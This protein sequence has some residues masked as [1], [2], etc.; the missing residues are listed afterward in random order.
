[1]KAQKNLR[2]QDIIDIIEKLA[3]KKLAEEWDNPGLLVG[4]PQQEVTGIL[5]CL[6]VSVPVVEEAIRLGANMIVS[7][8]PMIFKGIRHVRTDLYTGK[9]LQLLLSHNIAAYAAHTNL[10]IAE[11]GVN[12]VLAKAVGLERLEAFVITDAEKNA[13]LGRIGYLP[14]PKTFD[15]FT[16]MVKDGLHINSLRVVRG[17]EGPVKKVALCSGAGAE[18]IA[19]AAFK[20]A[21]VYLTGDVK[22]HDAQ[23]AVEQ[24]INL[25]DAGHFATEFPVV[26]VLAEYLRGELA[27]LGKTLEIST[28]KVSRDF[29]EFV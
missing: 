28:D 12:D 24:D 21:D 5:V 2:C 7:H 6:D 26:E 16:Q 4:S 1:M 19:K 13:S 11:G 25:I 3:P 17:K 23:K 10:D 27:E 9:L 15:E 20:G 22:Y 29:F 14:S 18:F 8:H